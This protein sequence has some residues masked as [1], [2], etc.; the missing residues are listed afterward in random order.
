M[1]TSAGRLVPGK[2]LSCTVYVYPVMLMV[3]R[4]GGLLCDKPARGVCVQARR[5]CLVRRLL[6][7]C[8]CALHAHADHLGRRSL[9]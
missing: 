3:G 6:E 1:P 8:C 9:G 7:R 2:R 4:V 5:L